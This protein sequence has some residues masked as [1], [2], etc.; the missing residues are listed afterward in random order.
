VIAIR[1]KTDNAAFEG[2]N[3]GIEVARIL[4]RLAIDFEAFGLGP[5]EQE[6]LHDI[7]RNTV[8]SCEVTKRGRK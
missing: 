4:R 5:G 6:N 3:Y 7:N 8:G 1:I 2:E